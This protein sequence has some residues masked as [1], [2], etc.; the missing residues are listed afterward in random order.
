[1]RP[2]TPRTPRAA[3]ARCCQQSP[4]CAYNA[5]TC[6]AGRPPGPAGIR[7]PYPPCVTPPARLS[8]LGIPACAVRD[9]RYPS[10]QSLPRFA[11][12]LPAARRLAAPRFGTCLGVRPYCAG[13]RSPARHGGHSTEYGRPLRAGSAAVRQGLAPRASAIRRAFGTLAVW[14]GL[15]FATSGP[16]VRGAVSA[17]VE[18]SR[19]SGNAVPPPYPMGHFSCNELP[20]TVAEAPAWAFAPAPCRLE[21]LSRGRSIGEGARLRSL[22]M[23]L[24]GPR[25]GGLNPLT[26]CSYFAHFAKRAGDVTPS[27]EH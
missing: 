8:R 24:F 16:P 19:N 20:A 13:R 7:Q 17:R 10:H 5:G 21:E 12:G 4:R 3:R 26:F 27:L 14:A 22:C 15:L 18:A 25:P 9:D 23:L 2:H 11:Q 6:S 1:M